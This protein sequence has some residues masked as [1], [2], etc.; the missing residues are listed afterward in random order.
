MGDILGLKRGNA[1]RNINDLGYQLFKTSCLKFI[2]NQSEN[3][4]AL[5]DGMNDVMS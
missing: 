3:P 2:K 1:V 5:D 4:S